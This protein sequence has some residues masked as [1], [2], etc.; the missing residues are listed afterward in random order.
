MVASMRSSMAA[1]AGAIVTVYLNQVNMNTTM[2]TDDGHE[3]DTDDQLAKTEIVETNFLN[4]KL[5]DI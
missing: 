5:F 4:L 3:H 1:S 2:T